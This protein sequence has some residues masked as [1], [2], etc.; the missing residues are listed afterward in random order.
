LV[1]EGRGKLIPANYNTAN[2]E[3]QVHKDRMRHCL[4][5]PS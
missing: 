5:T 4:R 1:K 2:A 3:S